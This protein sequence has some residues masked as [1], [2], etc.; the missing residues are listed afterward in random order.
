LPYRRAVLPETAQ[1]LPS[2]NLFW[3]EIADAFTE[4]ARVFSEFA[5]RRWGFEAGRVNTV[6]VR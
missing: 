2:G 3:A 1:R 5:M 6:I 4:E